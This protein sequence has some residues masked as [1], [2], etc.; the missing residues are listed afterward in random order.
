MKI[1][2]QKLY[3]VIY[4]VN[5]VFGFKKGILGKE[6]RNV[7]RIVISFISFAESDGFQK[8]A[9]VLSLYCYVGLS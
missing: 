6:R 2:Y 4:G 5:N 1:A 3:N 7:G 8:E 9:T